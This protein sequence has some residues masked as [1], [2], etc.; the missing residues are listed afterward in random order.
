MD[1]IKFKNSNRELLFQKYILA[2]IHSKI[3][4]DFELKSL[5]VINLDLL[6]PKKDLPSG[7]RNIRERLREKEGKKMIKL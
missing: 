5:A 3:L 6:Y 4:N 7:Y 2:E 1:R